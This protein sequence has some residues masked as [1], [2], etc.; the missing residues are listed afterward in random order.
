MILSTASVAPETG[1]GRLV[2]QVGKRVR[3]LEGMPTLKPAKKL[4]PTLLEMKF[5][6][7]G[8]TK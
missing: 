4:R 2:R 3:T 6:Q 5:M 8:K 1:D 7:R